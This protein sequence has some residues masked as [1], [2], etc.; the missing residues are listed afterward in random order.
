MDKK[1]ICTI[2]HSSAVKKNKIMKFADKW[3]EVGGRASPEE[4]YIF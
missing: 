4:E 2:K 3:V 1:T